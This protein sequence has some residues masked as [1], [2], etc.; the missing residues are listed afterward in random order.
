VVDGE[1]HGSMNLAKVSRL[2]DSYAKKES[3]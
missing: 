2:V 1:Y 3:A